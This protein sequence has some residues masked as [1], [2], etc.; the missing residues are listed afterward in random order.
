MLRL[1]CWVITGNIILMMA[2]LHRKLQPKWFTTILFETHAGNTRTFR[3]TA[4]VCSP[5]ADTSQAVF[6]FLF[7]TFE[8]WAHHQKET[9]SPASWTSAG[10]RC[11]RRASSLR[12]S[13]GRGCGGGRPS[14]PGPS[15]EGRGAEGDAGRGQLIRRRRWPVI[16]RFAFTLLDPDTTN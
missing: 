1:I 6:L 2:N 9:C 10:R 3:W 14:A 16:G 13:G 5:Q 8:L 4:S 15:G 12:W 7:L 11:R